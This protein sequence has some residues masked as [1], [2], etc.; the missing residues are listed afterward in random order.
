MSRNFLLSDHHFGHAKILDF[1]PSRAKFANTVQEHD[2]W[3]IARHNE[4]IKKRDNVWLLGDIA[5]SKEALD[6]CVPQM[7]GQLNLILGNHDKFELELYLKYFNKV[8]A[9]QPYKS[10]VLTHVPLHNRSLDRWN[11]N[12]HGHSH[13]SSQFS[14][15]HVN[16]CVEQSDGSPRTL[17][18]WLA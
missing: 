2:D 16:C 1:E 4:R 6:R 8:K 17:E 3:L 9:I 12:Y 11:I 18:E 14:D 10:G 13:S 5:F 7:N 15:Q